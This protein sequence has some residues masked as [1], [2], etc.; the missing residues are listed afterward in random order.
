MSRPLSLPTHD[1]FLDLENGGLRH[2][3]DR[4]WEV[5]MVVD[6][7]GAE[8]EL[9]HY[10]V[11]DFDPS[12]ADPMALSLAGFY[13]RHP[14][15][16]LAGI[17]QPMD[18]QAALRWDDHGLPEGDPD[19]P[20]PKVFT[21]AMP[22]SMVVR[23]LSWYLRD[24]R[25]CIVNPTFDKPKIERR[26]AVHGLA[27]TGY[28]TPVCIGSFAGGVLGVDPCGGRSNDLAAA[29]GVNRDDYGT[30]HTGLVDA[31]YGRAILR[32]AEAKAGMVPA[33]QRRYDEAQ[34]GAVEG[35]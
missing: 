26:L 12:N 3:D 33:W 28:Y 4:F 23:T 29:L 32:T 27:W 13:D 10:Y 30:N 2:D 34:A 21:D 7:P 25:V 19:G 14:L 6:V 20:P 11:S 24:A 18:P 35:G 16:R 31:L 9:H 1:V 22:E 17:G 8:T 15:H 5:G